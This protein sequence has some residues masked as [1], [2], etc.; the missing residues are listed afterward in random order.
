MAHMIPTSRK[1][2]E[3]LSVRASMAFSWFPFY[4]IQ[5]TSH[6]DG[7]P[8]IHSRSSLFG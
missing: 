2:D 7:A 4:S 6:W 3:Y 1:K 5:D 8:H